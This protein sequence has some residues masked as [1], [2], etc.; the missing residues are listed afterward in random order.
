MGISMDINDALKLSLG[1]L[2]RVKRIYNFWVIHASFFMLSHVSIIILHHFYA[3]CRTNLLTRCPVSVSCFCCFVF[4]KIHHRKYRQ[5]KLK[6]YGD[7]LCD[8]RHQKTEGAPGGPPRDHRRV[9]AVAPLGPMGGA[10]PCP[11][12]TASAPSDAYKFPFTLKTSGQP[13]FSTDR[14][15][16][17]LNS[18]H[19]GESR[20]PSSAW[21][22]CARFVQTSGKLYYSLW[23][24]KIQNFFWFEWVESFQIGRA[25][26]RERVYVLV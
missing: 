20:M 5:I 3:F 21:K 1:M 17:R 25:S 18:S 2:I 26:C 19:S 7:C 11:L 15:S 6:I 14:K 4:Q 8:G 12:G 23:N 13:L 16:T 22:N 10:R 9:P 24:G